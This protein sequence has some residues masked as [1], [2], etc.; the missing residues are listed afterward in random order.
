MIFHLLAGDGRVLL[1]ETYFSI[2]GGFISTLAE[3]GQ[4]AAP[5]KIE[6]DLAFPF[7]F[8]SA[9]AMLAMSR[10]SGSSIARMKRDNELV[11]TSRRG[12]DQGLDAI[13]AAMQTC[14]EGGSRPTVNC[15]AACT[16]GG[17]PRS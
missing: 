5:L 6:P 14:V 9:A 10:D 1:S 4:L 16:S 17:G 12:L 3:I 2:G 13:W 15:L 7:P 11:R 8:D